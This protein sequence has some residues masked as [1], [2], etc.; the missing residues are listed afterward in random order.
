MLRYWPTDFDWPVIVAMVAVGMMENSIHQIINM[1]TVRHRL[2]AASRTML[3]FRIVF[4]ILGELMAAL[5]VRLAD[6]KDMILDRFPVLMNEMTIDQEIDV[7]V[8][9]HGHV[10]A[11][12][13]V[14]MCGIRHDNLRTKER[15][16]R[17][18]IA[19]PVRKAES[20]ESRYENLSA[21]VG[22][23]GAE[24]FPGKRTR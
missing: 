21:D 3:V 9:F 4:L 8:V 12:R 18:R 7:A 23:A 14:G 2:V 11:T 13:T 19:P 17:S 1:I 24:W 20:E 15:K 6:R 16:G 10:T 22:P 5:W